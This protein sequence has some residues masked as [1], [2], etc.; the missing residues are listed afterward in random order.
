MGQ[1]Y[2]AFDPELDR[3]VAIKLLSR[4]V[5]SPQGRDRL[6]AEGRAMAKLTHPNVVAVYDVGSRG[7]QVFVAMEHI[8]GQT[9]RQWLQ[10]DERSWRDALEVF[11]QAGAGLA[12]AHAVGIV[13]QDFKPSNVMLAT[14]GSVR[15]VDF[16]LAALGGDAVTATA[17]G[18]T[19]AGTPGY[20]APERL[21]GRPPDARADQYSFCVALER[22][23]EGRGRHA[24]G[25]RPSAPSRVPL[26]LRQALQRGSATEPEDRFESMEELLTVISLDRRRRLRRRLS[27]AAL[28]AALL[29][30]WGTLQEVADRREPCTGASSKLATAWN[31]ENRSAIRSAFV[32]TGLPFADEVSDRVI[33]AAE[34]YAG[35]WQEAYT[36]ACRATHVLGEQSERVLD[37]R[38]DCLSDRLREL[39]SLA[40]LFVSAD[41]ELVSN[42]AEAMTRLTSLDACADVG[43]MARRSP[44]PAD[45]AARDVLETA[46][47]D[48]AEHWSRIVSGQ[49]VEASALDAAAETGR[50]LD[51]PPLESEAL[52]LAA[53]LQE[54]PGAAED[55]LHRA[56]RAAVAADSRRLEARVYSALVHNAGFLQSRFDDARRYGRLAEAALASVGVGRLEIEARL[57]VS[58]GNCVYQE[59]HAPEAKELYLRAKA[60]TDKIRGPEDPR[61]ANLYSNLAMLQGLEPEEQERALSYLE[62]ALRIQEAAFGP[63]NPN[64]GPSLINLA[65]FHAS[66]GEYEEAAALAE[67]CLAIQESF[68]ESDHRDMTFPLLLRGQTLIAADRAPEAEPPLRRALPLARSGFGEQ[69][70][71]VALVHLALVESLTWQGRLEEAGQQLGLAR[72]IYE[73]SLEPRQPSF[74]LDLQL[75]AGRLNMARQKYLEAIRE[76][77][78]AVQI[79]P[80]DLAQ[81]RD[82]WQL[83]IA[84]G[85]AHAELGNSAQAC[86]YL[87]GAIGEIRPGVDLHLAAR[88]R[89]AL[90]R[91]I[92]VDHPDRALQLAL[93]ARQDVD[94]GDGVQTLALRR[95]LEEW[96]SRSIVEDG[97]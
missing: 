17:P 27:L 35:D 75:Q 86:S 36:E 91:E 8:E 53:G 68:F 93:A 83:R 92:A 62:R 40:T 42:A 43:E 76:L 38:M 64:L 30:G 24:E 87:E 61:H 25:S 72:S 74:F 37:L 77:E 26:W 60:I 96:L 28:G 46:R 58:L 33:A 10:T 90:A 55:Y 85:E 23:L 13:H 3:R 34:R 81:S 4:S 65:S 31:S 52:L 47:A 79:G 97:S 5:D 69:S 51:Y 1:V 66:R 29:V 89:F 94:T 20:I 15:V 21:R 54:D 44:L 67:R 56:L 2:S 12:A 41:R 95:E 84:L 63:H 88:A 57:L 73:A 70:Y 48:V 32:A 18:A 14:D 9:L 78:L 45:P 6:H 7:D 50:A 22:A 11:S 80:A 82:A 59:G 19:V 71:F 49:R 16:G 39:R